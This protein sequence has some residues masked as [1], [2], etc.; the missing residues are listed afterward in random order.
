MSIHP[1]LPVVP[2]VVCTNGLSG[3][4]IFL[5]SV[6]GALAVSEWISKIHAFQLNVL[7][8]VILRNENKNTL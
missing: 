6:H 1:N 8:V 3:A 7:P 4:P 5:Y 2:F